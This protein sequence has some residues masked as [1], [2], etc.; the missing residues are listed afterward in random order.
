MRHSRGSKSRTNSRHL[1][2]LVSSRSISELLHLPYILY[3]KD[4]SMSALGINV[5]DDSKSR[6][7]EA[8]SE[9]NSPNLD[10]ITVLFVGY[11]N[12]RFSQVVRLR[13]KFRKKNYHGLLLTKTCVWGFFSNG[14]SRNKETDKF[15]ASK[16]WQFHCCVIF[17]FLFSSVNWCHHQ[18]EK[19][20][21][22][23]WIMYGLRTLIMRL[24]FC[25]LFFFCARFCL[26]HLFIW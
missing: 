14:K 9:E 15:L 26:L 16:F 7:D 3:I 18:H 25:C 23:D 12:L 11:K 6:D 10:P 8:D 2:P 19:Q 22:F 5:S 20:K 24:N 17:L 1:M 21:L 13:K 4:T